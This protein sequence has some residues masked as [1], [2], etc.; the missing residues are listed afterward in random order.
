MAVTINRYNH[1]AKRIMNSEV[2]MANLV[3]ILLSA[4]AAFTAAN[5]T[6]AQVTN[7]GANVVSGNG[8]PAAGLPIGNVEVTI[9]ATNGAMID[10]D[11]VTATATGGSIGPAFA[12]VIADATSNAPLWFIDFD[13]SQE[14]GDGTDFKIAFNT[15]GIARVSSA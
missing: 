15:A 12:A 10:G 7:S 1:T 5:T 8:W 4:A 11:D 13:G 3:V 14:A 9:A 6:V 2:D